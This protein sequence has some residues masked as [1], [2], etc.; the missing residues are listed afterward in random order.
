MRAL[1]FGLGADGTV[2]ANKNSI[3]IIG[4]DT[5]N[6]AQGYFVYD[7]KKSGTLTVS[8]LRFGPRPIRSAYLVAK[9][10]FIACHQANFVEKYEMLEPAAS[11][12]HVPAQLLVRAGRGL[13]EAAARGPAADP[14]QEASRF[15]VIDAYKVAKETGMGVRINTIMQT[16]FF[17]IS[18]VLPR[19]EAIGHIKK[20]IEKT[21]S[22]KGAE[23]VKKNFQA[24]DHT[25]AHL[26]EVKTQGRK[27]TGP[28]RPP[29]VSESAPD[30]VKRVTALM[31]AGNGDLLPVSAF[32][33]DGTW[34]L[35]TSRVGEALH[36]PRDPGVGAVALHPVQQV[37]AHLPARG[38]PA[39][40]LRGR[41]A[42]VGAEG[43]RH[44]GLQ[45]ARPEGHEVR[46]A[47]RAGRLH[48][49]L[50]VRR[51]LPGGVQDREGQVRH[52]HERGAPAQGEGAE[53]LRLLPLHPGRGSHEGEARREGNAVPRAALRVLR[54]L[55]RL[56]RDAVHQ[57]PHPALR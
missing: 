1:F 44:D 8:H 2:G 22:R 11:G 33:V 51:D 35:G 32:P 38:D 37:R 21:Y 3:K 10:N 16:C 14:R 53:E 20:T 6:Y 55:H 25:L 40:V 47:G 4:E 42:E 54:R 13:G 41:G 34:P 28:A 19:D 57:A 17:A 29:T 9:A 23:V 5:P 36:R 49:L 56:R 27:V 52:Q 45:V 48:G 43:L 30:F 24:V 15:Y 12:R 18:G 7:S 31:L 39:E 46:P 26:Y 50:A